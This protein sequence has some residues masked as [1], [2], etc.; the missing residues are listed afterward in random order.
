[1]VSRVPLLRIYVA[2]NDADAAYPSVCPS[3]T[4]QYGVKT[5]ERVIK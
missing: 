2:D 5:T 1:M 3:V 4:R